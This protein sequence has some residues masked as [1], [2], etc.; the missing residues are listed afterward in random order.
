MKCLTCNIIENAEVLSHVEVLP[1]IH[2]QIPGCTLN[3][4]KFRLV[5][6]KPCLQSLTQKTKFN[7][8]DV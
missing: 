4:V 1:N 3:V 8:R 2:S 5:V 6:R 7:S